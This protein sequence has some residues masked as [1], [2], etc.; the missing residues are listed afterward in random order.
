[1]ENTP[2]IRFKRQLLAAISMLLACCGVPV[3]GA[4]TPSPTVDQAP[5]TVQQP[6]PPNIV[7][8]LDD[9]G[10]MAW[11]VMPDICFLQN[12]SCTAGRG[13]KPFTITSPTDPYYVSATTGALEDSN[14]NGLYYN[15]TVTYTPPIEVNGSSYPSAP[16]T[17]ASI[18]GAWLNGMQAQ[19]GT[20]S[21]TVNL[22]TYT[23]NYDSDIQ[24]SSSGTSEAV[25]Y[26]TT[27]GSGKTKTSVF[28][29]Y[30]DSNAGAGPYTPHYVAATTC[31]GNTSCVIATDTSG[32]SAPINVPVGQNIANWYAY[33]HTRIMMTQSGL[34]IAFNA[35]NYNVRVGFGSI[36]GN[37]AGAITGLGSSNYFTYA[38][39]YNGGSN[40]IANVQQFDQACVAS[41]TS[42]CTPGASG[43]QR[44]NFWS[45]IT[46][47]TASGGT[48]TRQAVYEVGAYYSQ[49]L[50]AKTTSTTNPWQDINATTGK[51][52]SLACRQSYAILS[53]DGFWND[54]YPYTTGTAVGNADGT[55]STTT[56]TGTDAQSYTYIAAGPFADSYSNTLADIAMYFWMTDL[57]TGIA[58]EVPTNTADPAFWQHMTTFTMGLGFT[59]VGITPTGTTVPEI[60]NWADGGTAISSWSNST[61]WP[62]PSNA[63]DGSIYNIADLAHAAVDGH[64]GFYSATSPQSFASGIEDALSR[65]QARAGTGASLAANSTT[66][67]LGTTTYQALYYNGIW[68]GDLE[69]YSVNP[70]TGVINT[71][72][73]ASAYSAMPAPTARKVYTYNPT[74]GATVQFTAANLSSLSSAEQTALGV[75]GTSTTAAT[76][77]IN[78]MLGD[79]SNE[80]SNNGPYRNRQNTL[81]SGNP[82]DALGDIVDSQPVFVGA[83]NPNLFTNLTFTG[84]SSYSTYA[85]NNAT[86]AETIWVAANDGMLHAFPTSTPPASTDLV[87]SFAYLPAAVLT[88]PTATGIATYSNPAYGTSSVPHQDFN[89]GQLTVADAYVTVSGASAAAWRTILV[90]TTGR[91]LAR[92]V[93]AFDI[94]TPSSPTFLWERSAGDGQT[95]SGYIGQMVGQPVI[96]QTG[97]GVWSVLIGNG[98]NSSKGTAALLQFDLMSG[99]LNVYT[100]NNTTGNGLAAPTTWI[101]NATNEISTTAYA[102]DV[103]GNI[104]AFTLVATTANGTV[105]GTTTTPQFV[106]GS[107]QPI[108]S[109][110]LAGEDPSTGN[111]WLFFGTGIYLTQNDIQNTNTQTWYGIIVQSAT[112]TNP[113]VTSATTTSNLMLRTITTECDVSSPPNT[114]CP[115]VSTRIISSGSASDLNGKSGWYLNLTSPTEGAQGE[116]MVVPNEFQGNALIGTTLIPQATDP[117]N[118]GGSGWIMAIS[119]FTG[120]ALAKSFF[121]GDS[122]S[123]IGFSSSPNDPIFVGN[124]MLTSFSNST[125]SSI[126]TAATAGALVRESWREMIDH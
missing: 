68:V 56:I 31:N 120:A 47:E 12:V 46:G 64:G 117:C 23:G 108:T 88:L 69:E 102:G 71:P 18:T 119:P 33:Y 96:A 75:S 41:T 58:N 122:S 83:P 61:S 49:A 3:L 109:G 63:G 113:A 62:Q 101:S 37:N 32:T 50:S 67:Q 2:R 8:M 91:G 45:W 93:Y 59:P 70:S 43:T 85:S 105:I 115:T 28:Q 29:Y 9:S 22:T 95:N 15:P 39:N 65:A 103:L 104:W 14:N 10:S 124:N 116:R 4:T 25:V 107:T 112:S 42:P 79:A 1:M 118:P 35:L 6:L 66:L 17:S 84:S 11:D 13:G 86:R 48:P 98:Y 19:A 97:A 99:N 92:A 123:A 7:L 77:L 125:I 111:V 57:Q 76:N 87:E 55:S 82:H 30:T 27:I 74:S 38:D 78:Y 24:F 36:D 5:L 72:A 34:T 114:S 44:N 26:S 54:S 110:L 51:V 52:E 21:T 60:F 89:D 73:V 53:T 126:Q 94:T 20:N 121:P 90:G 81:I 106:T 80:Q 16:A 40:Y 100:T